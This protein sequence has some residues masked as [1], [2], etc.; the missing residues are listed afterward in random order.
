MKQTNFDAGWTFRPG[1]R[2]R[3]RPEREALVKE[4]PITLPH[5]FTISTDPR[6]DAPGAVS[7]GYYA[8][9]YGIY[10]KEFSLSE[11]VRGQTVLLS[12]DGV[13]RNCEV[14]INGQLVTSHPYGYTAF[15]ADLTDH[16]WF[17]R[18]NRLEVTV[19][20]SAEPNSRWY[21]G[22][23]I[24]RSVELLTAPPLHIAPWGIFARTDRVD[25]GTGHLVVET[26]VDNAT[27]REAAIWITATLTAP[28]GQMAASGK[29]L[30]TVPAG[31]SGKG[32]VPLTVPNA[33][34]W[35]LDA[36]LLYQVRSDISEDGTLMDTAETSFGIRT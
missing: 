21:S 17:D 28:E 20:N 12:F 15:Q 13:Y 30:L 19:N 31:S 25:N 34:L 32:T 8:G 23:G 6:P 1:P 26:T 27:D 11:D 29:T 3:W 14:V 35:E 10:S 22:S 18:P 4:I 33:H 7:T 2:D 24:Y 9:G 36:P 16:L 5:D